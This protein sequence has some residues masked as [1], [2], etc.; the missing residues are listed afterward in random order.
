MKV[1]YSGNFWGS[2]KFEHAGKEISIN[3]EFWWGGLKWRI[4]AAYSCSKG[5]VMDFCVEIPRER[6]EN[7][8]EHWNHD[9]KIS[10]INA[11]ELEQRE[12][13]N[14]FSFD[15]EV[16]AKIDGKKLEYSGMCAVCWYPCEGEREQIEDVQEEL[17]EYYVCDRRHGW[18]F[19][20]V[21]FPWRTTRKPEVM[22]VS[23]TLKERPVGY[24]GEH[25]ITEDSCY[26]QEITC[27]HPLSKKK[28]KITLYGC[29]T[30][31]LPED[32]FRF[33]K[34]ILFPNNYR[35]LTFSISPEL[36]QEEFGI[37]DCARGD[38][39]R[40]IITNTFAS[41]EISS[42]GV[43]IIGGACGPSAIFIADKS[44]E[45]HNRRLACS[46]LNFSPV[47]LIEW[48]TIFYVKQN[49]D[50]SINIDL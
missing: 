41:N 17:M 33:N 38:K 3:K 26:G 40:S 9:K 1:Y 34:D 50:L 28:Y 47:S 24:S 7:F 20:R 4:P 21:C 37:H 29:K 25:F 46:S 43:A 19:I 10:G 2:H 14:P 36:P 27:I 44:S 16:E 11:E 42:C 30:N 48:R 12:K 39:P 6:C 35:M 18:R 45:K 5:L 49:E 13:K 8:Y 22:K 31:T 23:L 15:I 32:S